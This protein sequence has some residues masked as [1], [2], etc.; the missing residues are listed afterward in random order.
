MTPAMLSATPIAAA[1]AT[2]ATATT[3]MYGGTGSGG[4]GSGVRGG[5]AAGEGRSSGVFAEMFALPD[6][7][8]QTN[9]LSFSLDGL[10]DDGGGAGVAPATDG[11]GMGIALPSFDDSDGLGDAGSMGGAMDAGGL[12][13]IMSDDMTA[14][15]DDPFSLLVRRSIDK[16]VHQTSGAAAVGAG[17]RSRR[18]TWEAM[19]ALPELIGDYGASGGG[20]AA[21]AAGGGGGGRPLGG[22]FALELGVLD[23][24]LPQ[25]ISDFDLKK[26]LGTGTYGK[27]CCTHL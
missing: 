17:G 22:S 8:P 7:A 20:G 16:G 24:A 14:I 4:G 3:F 1:A 2:T 19:F 18:G 6:V 12:G 15:V 11:M 23:E 27:V 25:S 9:R 13:S 26:T 5:G 21:P 10:G